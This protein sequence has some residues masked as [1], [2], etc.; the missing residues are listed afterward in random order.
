MLQLTAKLM[1]AI[2]VSLALAACVP[3]AG[4]IEAGLAQPPAPKL[5]PDAYGARSDSGFAIPALPVEEIPAQF[6]RQAVYFP[7][8]EAPGTIIINPSQRLLH[9][10]TGKN[11]AMR[12]G[13][14][15]GRDGFQWSG[16]AIVAERKLWPTW[17]PPEEMI[18]RDPKLAKWEK[19]QPGG[20]TNPLGSRAIYLTSNG[21]DYGYRIHGTPDWKSIGRNASSGCIRMINQDVMDLYEKV[22]TGTKVIVLN[23]DGSTPTEMNLPP[24]QPKKIK[25]QAAAPAP[26]PIIVQQPAVMPA[27]IVTGPKVELAQPTAGALA[28]SVPLVNGA[29]PAPVAAP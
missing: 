3:D 15:V 18:E 23:A 28:C 7:S 5:V 12:Y 25:V 8:D 17:T 20:P 4:M 29:C 21:I 22:G 6:Q 2:L 27:P 19:G 1:A 24:P 9:L 26:A 10:I 13:I 14:A 11:Q 16:E